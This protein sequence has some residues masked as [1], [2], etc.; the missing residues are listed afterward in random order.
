M[1][2]QAQ[3]KANAAGLANVRFFRADAATLTFPRDSFDCLF[4]ASGLV[5]MADIPRAPARWSSFLKAGGQIAF[6]TPEA[7]FGLLE[8]LANAAGAHGLLLPFATLA[9]TQ[10]KCRSLLSEAGL[11]PASVRT[12]R[13]DSSRVNLGVAKA[14]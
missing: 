14:L 2:R 7:P 3:H 9:D 10:A 5:F 4:C 11:E 8:M 1:L 6:D 12:K 13:V